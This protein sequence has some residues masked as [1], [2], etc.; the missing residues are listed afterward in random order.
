V[1]RKVFTLGLTRLEAEEVF[2]VLGSSYVEALPRSRR[3]KAEAVRWRLYR[4]LTAHDAAVE[5]RRGE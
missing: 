5:R 2:R 4:M 1:S 3:G